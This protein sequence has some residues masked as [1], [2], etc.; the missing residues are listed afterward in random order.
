[1]AMFPKGATV[2]QVLP[3]PVVGTVQRYDVDQ[4]TGEVQVLV[5]WPDAN[6]DGHEESHYFKVA[7]L[8]LV[9]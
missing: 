4:E 9:E 1:M 5:V 6:G 7:E 2:R 3:P 8:E